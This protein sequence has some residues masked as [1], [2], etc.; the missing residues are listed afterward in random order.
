ML[1]AFVPLSIF[2]VFIFCLPAA[3]TEIPLDEAG[4]TAFVA[5]VFKEKHSDASVT[6][7]GPLQL[8]I[9][10]ANESWASYLFTLYSYCMRNPTTCEE[11]IAVH[12]EQIAA[13]H[14]DEA[15]PREAT[16]L[17]IVVRQKIYVDQIAANLAGRGK[18]VAE[19]LAGDLWLLAV[20][21]RPT[22]VSFLKPKD[23]ETLH[24]TA[25]AALARAKENTK[26]MIADRIPEDPSASGE[27]SVLG[28]DTYQASLLAFPDL[29]A[30]LA[31]ANDNRLI[32]AVPG[33]DVILF[34]REDK[35][36]S[37]EALAKVAEATMEGEFRPF[38]PTVFRWTDKGW[39]TVER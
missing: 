36:E 9:T 15:A 33:A 31:K 32:V 11:H 17:R 22:T 19:A 38:S 8:N 14:K 25:E 16:D 35:S 27:I 4:F 2:F 7:A 29:W 3:A 20:F 37:V 18:P 13:S 28:D 5:K 1:R 39:I 10:A 24:L 23:L 30:P 6:V 12:A 21:D 34:T 26:A